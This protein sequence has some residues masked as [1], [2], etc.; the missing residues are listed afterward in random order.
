MHLRSF[1]VAAALVLTLLLL[2]PETR[3]GGKVSDNERDARAALKE[4]AALS[5]QAKTLT[6]DRCHWQVTLV[7][8]SEVLKRAEILLANAPGAD[9]ALKRQLSKLAAALAQQDKDRRLLEQLEAIRD[10]T[11][12]KAGLAGPQYE[13]VFR[14]YGLL[15][16]EVD[17][18]K[19]GTR[20]RESSVRQDICAALDRWALLGDDKRPA[21]KRL[22]QWLQDVLA[23]ADPDPWRTRLRETLEKRDLASL[24]KLATD[25]D[26]LR[27]PRATLV[28]LGD[29]LAALGAPSEAIAVLRQA[30]QLY[31]ADFG[32]NHQ[33]ALHLTRLQPPRWHEAVRFLSAALAL[34]PQDPAVR[35]HLGTALLE[36][37]QVEEPRTVLREAI[38]LQPNS[39]EAHFHFGKVLARQCPSDEAVAAFRKAIMLQPDH[40]AAHHQL[41]LVLYARGKLAEAI[42]ALHQSLRLQPDHAPAHNDLA[43]A[44]RG[45]GRIAEAIAAHRAAPALQPTSARYHRDFGETLAAVQKLDEAIAAYRNAIELEPQGGGPYLSLGIALRRKG[46]LDEAIAILRKA[47]QINPGIDGVWTQL[48]HA[49]ADKGNLKE[50]EAAYREA[51]RSDSPR[52]LDAPFG[53]GQVLARQGRLKDA[54]V[55]FKQVVAARP[56][57]AEAHWELGHALKRQGQFAE[58]LAALERGQQVAAK[59]SPW[60]PTVAGWVKETERLVQLDTRLPAILA[61]KEAPGDAVE[62]I[63]YARVCRYKGLTAAS[64]RFYAEAFAA[65]PRLAADAESANRYRAACAAVLAGSGQGEDA[66]QLEVKERARLRQQAL[67][68]LRTDLAAD[69]PGHPPQAAGRRPGRGTGQRAP[70]APAMAT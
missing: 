62:R 65:D 14:E 37:G 10:Q 59:A 67:D 24:K 2:A 5:E 29:A 33:L 39:A 23:E 36:V 27:Q 52:H 7:K 19:A 13:D 55:L 56:E 31:P 70:D 60:H 61:G 51:L 40:A 42:A 44:L 20:L 25:S 57:W 28:L 22:R 11:S 53:L 6:A 34:R 26:L 18:A 46:Q 30:Q 66:D 54:V 45:S 38:K 63:E 1:L 4:A 68:W 35:V 64:A 12:P 58:A 21:G 9:P 69:R 32:I 50:A 48:G 41:A 8:A 3:A 49:L 16:E 47:I 17:A 43:L 15:A